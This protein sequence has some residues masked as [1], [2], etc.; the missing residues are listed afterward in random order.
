MS[1]LQSLILAT[2]AACLANCGVRDAVAAQTCLTAAE[3]REAV[4]EHKLA[5]PGA[6]QREAAR[7]SRGEPLRSRLC[8]WNN[9]YVYEITLLRRDG[10]VTHVFIAAVDGRLLEAGAD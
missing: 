3:S 4:R 7:Q 1:R 5:R 10:K 9:D 2:V 6:V 8:R